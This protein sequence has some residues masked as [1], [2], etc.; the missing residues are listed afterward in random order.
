MSQWH[1]CRNRGATVEAG[2][3]V[4]ALPSAYLRI[5]V[6]FEKFRKERVQR[7]HDMDAEL[8]KGPG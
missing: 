2:V 6:S 4:G 3:R 5:I 1:P 8:S 7:E